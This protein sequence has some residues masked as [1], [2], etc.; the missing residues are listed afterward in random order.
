MLRT[1]T[2]SVAIALVLGATTARAD[3]IRVL[4]SVGIKTVVDALAPQFEKTTKHR[5]TTVFDLASVLKTKIEGGEAFDVAIL[6][7]PL[8]DDLIAKKI[9][10]ASSRAAV[11]RVGLGLMI[12][13][14]APKPDVSSIAAFT[15]TLVNAKS[16][17]YA[18]AGASGIAFL[19]IVDKLGIAP[20]VKA[21]ARPEATTEA[22]GHNVTSGASDFAVLPVSEILPVKGAELGGVFPAEVQTFVVMAAGV[23]AKAQGRAAQDFVAFLMS[24]A[25]TAIVRQM[26]MERLP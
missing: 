22:V 23:S 7:P 16:I 12:R 5:V 11:A 9:V 3:E 24:P 6:T 14:G 21:K 13:A 10:A 17:T 15:R 26:G 4:S 25:N 20:A 2:T 19:A 8:L 1:I 18:S